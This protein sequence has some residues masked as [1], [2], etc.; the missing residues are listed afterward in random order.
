M[1][2]G[3]YSSR[4]S[5]N[6]LGPELGRAFVVERIGGRHNQ[7]GHL[8]IRG[9]RPRITSR[10]KPCRAPPGASFKNSNRK[11]DVIE[12]MEEIASGEDDKISRNRILY[13]VRGLLGEASSLAMGLLAPVMA[14]VAKELD[15]SLTSKAVN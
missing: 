10:A 5:A 4:D 15:T 3:G 8:E 1:A 14:V 12:T 7:R 6:E 11:K 2:K 9:R 13:E